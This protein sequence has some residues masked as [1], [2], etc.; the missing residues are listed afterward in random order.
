MPVSEP[1]STAM[2]A[3]AIRSSIDSASAPSPTNSSTW[4]VPPRD[5]DLRDHGEDDVLAG[6]EA[7]LL[8]GDVD[9]DR[10]RH[11]LPELAEGEAGGDVGRA[12]AGAERAE[13]AVRARV[14][15]AA[16]DDAARDDPALL[17]EDGVLDA[18]PAL[19]VERVRP[20]PRDQSLSRFWSSAER[21]SLAGMK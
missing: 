15:V 4:F 16:G 3:T 14:R 6:D 17:D 18:A 5:A 13:R 20:V 9:L 21:A 1:A 10:P 11:G 12:E 2:F 7:A 19:V 8:A